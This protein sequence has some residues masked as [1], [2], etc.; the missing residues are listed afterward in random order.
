VYSSYSLAKKYAKYYLH[1]SN[2]K[3]H[4]V[5]SPFVFNFIKFVLNDHTKYPVYPQV[6]AQRK[7]LLKDD[8]VIQV[9]DFG[10]GSSLVK[11][12]ERSIKK[13]AAS[14]LKPRKY[15]QLLYRM[16]AHLKPQTMVELGTSL[17]ITTSYLAKAAPTAEVYTLEGSET[18]SAKAMD[19]FSELGIDNIKLTTGNFAD[20]LPK[21]L[22]EI[23]Q[24]DF[25]FVDGNHRK[26]PTLEYFTHLLK[27]CNN[28]SVIVFDD[29]HWSA[30]M[31]EAWEEIKA[32]DAV[33]LSIDL[34]FIGVV[35]LRK[36]F[37]A[38]QHFSIRF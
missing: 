34:F 19:T 6:E 36:D 35:F 38:K 27:V 31:E 28:D 10:A 9:E 16:V 4:G 24:V 12:K 30:E 21:L 3:G 17:G 20:T 26:E 1:A 2:R 14:S 22:N 29:I 11:T 37:K 7:L 33:T 15:S 13:I 8:T 5:H 25:A 18:I 23:P 32:N